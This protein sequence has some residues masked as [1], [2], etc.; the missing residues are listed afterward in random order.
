LVLDL[1]LQ[2]QSQL[3]LGLIEAETHPYIRKI[4][5]RCDWMIDVG[6]GEGELALYF[7]ANGAK[8]FAIEPHP[9][10]I[11]RNIELNL[12]QG[13][14]AI[15]VIP[16]FAGLSA[17]RL[18]D[19]PVS[20]AKRGFIKIDVE[21]CEEDVLRSAQNILSTALVCLLVET[22]S[23]DLEERCRSLLQKN[24]LETEIIRNAWWRKVMPE[25][26]PLP[27]NRWLWAQPQ[28]LPQRSPSDARSAASSS[29]VWPTVLSAIVGVA[30]G[31]LSPHL[32]RSQCR[33]GQGQR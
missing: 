12:H 8:V 17:A 25:R 29:M 19:I 22:H 33:G 32:K 13:S 3:Y 20:R 21:G 23:A 4:A 1:D 30:S 18:D 28:G 14:P 26:R 5:N 15:T 16:E 24:G 27:H 10:A 6:A 11:T 9:N 31:G 7:A 2:H